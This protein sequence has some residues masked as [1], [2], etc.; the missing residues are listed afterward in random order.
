MV[1]INV[2]R[3]EPRHVRK[4]ARRGD[5]M[6][7]RST[8]AMPDRPVLM[9]MR[10]CESGDCTARPSMQMPTSIVQ[11]RNLPG[12]K[13][14]VRPA[15]PDRPVCLT[16]VPNNG[17]PTAPQRRQQQLRLQLPLR[18]HPQS[19][20]LLPCNRCR[21]HTLNPPPPNPHNAT[22]QPC[23]I[24]RG[25]LLWRLSDDSPV[26]AATPTWGPSS[27]THHRLGK[28]QG[29]HM[30]SGSPSKADLRSSNLC[31][32]GGP[33]FRGQQCPPSATAALR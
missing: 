26:P 21:L 15:T 24:S 20:K 12:S 27:E 7:L 14:A 31:I 19:P 2:A 17:K 29:E 10:P 5:R 23:P 8:P 18:S 3:R 16:R 11:P 25:F 32:V 33:P 9:S 13:A 6:A 4:A 22:P 28:A 1:A 30:C